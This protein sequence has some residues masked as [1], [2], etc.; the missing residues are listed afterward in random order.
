MNLPDFFEEKLAE[1][2]RL[3]GAVYT[4]IAQFEPWLLDSKLP[5]FPDYTDHGIR[6]LESVIATAYS[7]ISSR[8]SRAD[9]P[10]S[11]AECLWAGD[12]AVLILAT[13]F[14]DLALHFSEASFFELIHGRTKSPTFPAFKDKP[15][16]DVWDRFLFA[17]RRW[18]EPVQRAIFG[19]DKNGRLLAE[20]RDPFSHWNDLSDGDKKLVGEFIRTNHGRIAQECAIHGVPGHGG[21]VTELPKTLLD[22]ERELIGLV[23]RSHTLPLRQCVD[24]LGEYFGHRRVCHDTHPAYVMA[25]LRIADYLQVDS[26]SDAIVF[27]Y[28]RIPSPFSTLEHQVAQDVEIIVAAEDD[29]ELLNVRAKPRDVATFLRIQEWLGGVQS[30]IDASWA[31][32]GETYGP[33]EE[34]RLLGLGGLKY[35]RIRSDIDDTFR[36]RRQKD[37]VPSRIRFD[38]VRPDLLALL[39]GPLYGDEPSFGIR[40]LIQNAVDAVRECDAFIASRVLPDPIVRRNQPCDVIVA[41]S[42]MDE[43]GCA[44]ITVSDRGIG[45]TEDVVQN[46]F[47]RAGASFRTSEWWRSEFEIN[48]QSDRRKNASVVLRSGRFGI[49]ALAS[50]LIGQSISVE[51]RHITA[52]EGLRFAAN[53]E[54]DPI[55]VTRDTTIPVGTSVTVRVSEDAYRRLLSSG[56]TTIRPRLWDWYCLN[57]PSVCRLLPKDQVFRKNA[58]SFDLSSGIGH[59]RLLEAEFPYRVFWTL[60]QA[61]ALMCNGL[62]VSDSQSLSR[63]PAEH[64]D[65]T[66][67][68]DLLSYP[69]VAVE[70]PDAA[71]PL[72][73]QRDGL[74][75]ED[76]PFGRQLV[77]DVLR[78]MLSWLFFHGPEAQFPANAEDLELM[79]WL[80][81]SARD[82]LLVLAPEGYGLRIASLLDKRRVSSVIFLRSP[83]TILN[84]AHPHTIM[85]AGDWEGYRSAIIN[86]LH[87]VSEH[88]GSAIPK[89]ARL[90]FYD[91]TNRTARKGR[92]VHIQDKRYVVEERAENWQILATP[93]FPQSRCTIE[94]P[95]S[96]N[97]RNFGSYLTE[98]VL[99]PDS[100]F[101]IA[102]WYLDDVWQEYFG[103]N[104]IPYN[105]GERLKKFASVVPLL[106]R[107]YRGESSERP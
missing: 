63:V 79:P 61:P 1:S 25:L 100:I 56:P 40:E 104:W 38:V 73:L 11:P 49:G 93:R 13:L 2:S 86:R 30:E 5:F 9:R 12:V 62:F 80:N 99:P 7:L 55:E 98:F 85:L 90:L 45:M 95:P 65:R 64:L 106:Q 72:R 48:T 81:Y 70:D 57:Y 97:R 88:G 94:W 87:I 59:W 76:Y 16:S 43:Q 47:F 20:T 96:A 54:T 101:S 6:H 58:Y 67:D 53:L 27:R 105:K 15:W 83:V 10:R 71:L 17:A 21:V 3:R 44:Y 107:Y 68:P 28:K 34:M 50:F 32:L 18:D 14:H 31:V 103:R 82:E 84:G 26:R 46:Y 42:A 37:Y 77:K 8:I 24:Q 41:L 89:H 4:C 51:T 19:V 52:Q 23:A 66:E 22:E 39:I 69:R 33:V 74:R 92:E 35:R 91:S 78:D 102:K 60:D 75:T 36:L 29:P